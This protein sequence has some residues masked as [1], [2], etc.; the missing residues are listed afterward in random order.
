MKFQS[1]IQQ[2]FQTVL[3]QKHKYLNKKA[4]FSEILIKI[5]ESFTN[6][7]CNGDHAEK[8]PIG[9]T[10]HF[11]DALRVLLPTQIQPYVWQ[12][13]EEAFP[14]VNIQRRLFVGFY[15]SSFLPAVYPALCNTVYN[16]FAV[17]GE[18]DGARHF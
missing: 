13:A 7:S 14:Q 1:Q 10:A 5:L 3:L 18:R 8:Q 15:P 9:H 2:I 6:W 12:A 11:Q 17:C 16:I 4:R